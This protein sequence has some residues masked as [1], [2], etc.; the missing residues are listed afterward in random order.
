MKTTMPFKPSSFASLFEVES[1]HWWFR[2]RNEV[3]LWILATKVKPFSKYLEIGCGTGNVLEAVRKAY[4][5]VEL[6]GSE[7]FEEGLEFA[8]RRVPSATF[9]K[10]DAVVMK[11]EDCYDFIGAFDVLE[12]IGEDEKVLGNIA[13]ALTNHGGIIITVPQHMWLWSENDLHACHARRYSRSELIGKVQ[14]AGLKV[15]YVTS[16]VSMLMPLMWMSR[17]RIRRVDHDPMSEFRISKRLNI[18]LK[19][20]MNVELFLIK[21]GLCFPFGGSLLLV[22]HK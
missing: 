5:H 21:I 9:Y 8:R 1:N 4:P 18:L 2:A 19:M 17:L 3:I 11:D 22:A 15:D 6:H 7:Y 12:H 14:R 13:K 10:L 16:F 20:I